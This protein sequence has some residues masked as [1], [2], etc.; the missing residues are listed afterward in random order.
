M[1]VEEDN[2]DEANE[3]GDVMAR[4]HKNHSKAL[5]HDFPIEELQLQKISAFMTWKERV[6]TLS[7]FVGIAITTGLLAAYRFSLEYALG[8]FFLEIIFCAILI[9]TWVHGKRA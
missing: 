5:P 7:V 8:I 6:V 2:S 3:S 4:R 1:S 9:L